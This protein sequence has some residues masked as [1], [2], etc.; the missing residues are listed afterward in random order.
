MRDLYR[1]LGIAKHATP[2]TIFRA[3]ERCDNH[4]LKADAM[5]ALGDPARRRDYDDLHALLSDLG[6]LRAGLGMTHAPH[7]QGDAANDFSPAPERIVARQ[8]LLTN[9][10]EIALRRHQTRWRRGAWITLTITISLS[11]AY[12]AGRWLA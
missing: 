8:E 7:W 10:L 4:S 1:R 5:C 11:A 12:A 3:A 2:K 9:K 6:R